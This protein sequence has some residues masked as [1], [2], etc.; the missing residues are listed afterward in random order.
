[1]SKIFFSDPKIKYTMFITIGTLLTIIIGIIILKIATYGIGYIE[2]EIEDYSRLTSSFKNA[3]LQ[4]CWADYQLEFDCCGVHNPGDMRFKNSIEI[5]K[6]RYLIFNDVSNYSHLIHTT[7][8]LCNNSDK[9]YVKG[10]GD[11]IL[12]R[13]MHYS[14]Q[15]QLFANIL[16]PN[17]I[18]MFILCI[19][20]WFI[21]PPVHITD[22]KMLGVLSNNPVA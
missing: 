7:R 5:N 8:L 10:C 15:I 20:C 3:D 1:M 21:I 16:I 6:G 9:S 2:R 17:S 22:L 18:M 13:L 19:F 14:D 12:D 4:R 11:I